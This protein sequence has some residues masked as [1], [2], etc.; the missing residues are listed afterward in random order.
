MLKTALYSVFFF[1]GT[2]LHV[3]ALAPEEVMVLANRNASKSK[4]IAKYY[5]EKRN[6]P[7]KNL[8]LLWITDKET[9]SRED[10]EKKV[11]VPVRRF[12]GKNKKIRCI[13]TIYGLP[14]RIA[15]PELTE[16]ELFEIEKM[17]EKKTNFAKIYEKNKNSEIK[18]ELN[19]IDRQLMN[20]KRKLDKTAS[21]D[22]ELFLVKKDNYDLK[23]WIPNPF[24]IEFTNKEIFVKK[25]EVL[26]VSRID[27]PDGDT[28][29][30]IIDDSLF[31]EKNGLKG[32]AY[33]DA[34]WKY[35]ENKKVKGYGLY[36]KSIHDAFR[37]VK[38]NNIME[39]VLNDTGDLFNEGECLD[40]A[41][42]CGWYSHGNYIDSF[43]WT[44]GSVGYHI[45]S[46]EC[47][48]LKNPNSN[49]WCKKM[50]D[51]GIAA[52]I[53]PVGEP[54]VQSFPVPEFFFAYF[55]K[56]RFTLAE[57][58]LLSIPYISWKMVLVGDPLY[59]FNI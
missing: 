17:N 8:L 11:I 15:A 23:M 38:K 37:F 25:E 28:C 51:K 49:V 2:A 19:K 6:I 53:G 1:I 39:T 29:K 41:I 55:L 34:R 43:S 9:C 47:V 18:K 12:L 16:D 40:A 30:R 56:S 27:G 26:M 13:V 7:E 54:Y 20:F 5:M 10:Y 44:R 59:K 52:T 14:I 22:S 31:A 42:Y 24:F 57:A 21:F 4:G 35:P 50:L 36:D 32:K 46:S 48:T 33:F 45:A 58:Y 3:F